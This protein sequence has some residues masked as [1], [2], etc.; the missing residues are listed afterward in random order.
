MGA[1]TAGMVSQGN[2]EQGVATLRKIAFFL[3]ERKPKTVALLSEKDL[4]CCFNLAHFLSFQHQKVLFIDCN[5]TLPSPTPGLW[6]YLHHITPSIPLLQ[7]KNYHFLPSGEKT[8]YGME[9]LASAAFQHLLSE[10]TPQYDFIFLLKQ[11]P[12]ASQEALQLLSLA[13][14]AVIITAEESLDILHPYLQWARQKEKKCATFAQ[15][16]PIYV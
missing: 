3:L 14:S 6:Q 5:F 4:S 15:H 2:E 12:L 1:E 13:H 11:A 16:V 7:E 8:P 10:L 9:M